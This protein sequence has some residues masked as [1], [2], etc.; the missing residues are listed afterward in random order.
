VQADATVTAHVLG[1]MLHCVGEFFER[2]LHLLLGRHLACFS[3]LPI[4][5]ALKAATHKSLHLLQDSHVRM[6]ACV[7]HVLTTAPTALTDISET[8][9]KK[10]CVDVYNTHIIVD[11]NGMHVRP[12]SALS[13]AGCCPC[14]AY[15]ILNTL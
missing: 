4:F 15:D 1:F 8:E 7:S 14:S 3:V 12:S 5:T 2:S 11:H 9:M 6:T 10:A 13:W